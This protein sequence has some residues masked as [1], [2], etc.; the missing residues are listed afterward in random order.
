VEIVHV[1]YRST[2]E[3]LRALVGGDLDFAVPVLA[4]IDSAI[5]QGQVRP[6]AVTSAQRWPTMPDIPTTV[7]S[8]FPEIPVD[9]WNGLFVPSKTSKSVVDKIH[10]EVRQVVDEPGTRARM[11]QIFYRPVGSTPKELADAMTT[12]ER[13]VKPLLSRLG[14]LLKP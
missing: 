4:A 12:E 11:Q 14:L 3:L 2:P 6:L 8:G 5:R 7:E 13:I 10:A 1:P 9:V